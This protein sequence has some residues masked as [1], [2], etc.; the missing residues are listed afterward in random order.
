MKVAV[1]GGTGLVGK[2]LCRYLSEQGHEAIVLSRKDPEQAEGAFGKDDHITFIR[3]LNESDKPEKELEGVDAIVNLAGASIS[4]R[5]TEEYK[6]QIVESRLQS[7][8]E[9]GRIISSMAVKPKVLINASAVGIYDTSH[10]KTFTEEDSDFGSDFLANTTKKWEAAALKAG[11]GIRTVLCRFG[12]ILDKEE[13]ALPRMALP[14]RLF[15]GGTVG[16]GTQWLS[17]IDIKDVVRGITFA[18]ETGELSGPV[19]F[20]AP[21]PVRIKEF[22]KVLADVLGRPHW[23]PAPSF[24]IKTVLGEMSILVLEGQ[25]ALPEKLERNG[26]SFQYPELKKALSDIFYH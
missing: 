2:A 26:F 24:A 19:N 9:I 14:Y 11:S 16:K 21:Q 10:A 6:K 13:G 12:V 17:W 3:W 1:T 25:K 18:I 4:K 22:G 20:T 7:A 8:A 23:L 5:W 15:A